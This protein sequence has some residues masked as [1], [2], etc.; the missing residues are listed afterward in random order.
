[1]APRI[2]ERGLAG[3]FRS[4]WGVAIER[5]GRFRRVP[6]PR[7]PGPKLHL[8]ED[9]NFAYDL[10]A[11]GEHAVLAWVAADGSIRLAELR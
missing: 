10:A 3:V 9:F 1:M 4:R 2:L 7:G 8:G 6:A 5:D 11:G